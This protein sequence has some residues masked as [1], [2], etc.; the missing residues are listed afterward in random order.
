MTTNNSLEVVGVSKSFAGL[1]ALSEVSLCVE[2]GQIVGL[3]GPNGAGKTTLFNTLSGFIK[4]DQGSIQFGGRNLIGLKPDK[5]CK[6]GIARTFQIVKPFGEL[7]V[8]QNVAVGAFNRTS[9]AAEAEAEAWRVLEFVGLENKA[10]VPARSLT[11]SDRKR[12]EMARALATK[13]ELLLLD[14]VMAGLNPTEKTEVKHLVEKVRVAGTAI[15]IIEH[16]IR[17]IMDL[18][19]RILVIQYGCCIAEGDPDSISRDPHVIEAYMGKAYAA[20]EY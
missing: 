4:P 12:L 1:K 13:P 10:L 9:H 16:A 18:C 17:V 11:T 19:D 15:L 7:T 20:A 14:E 5:I 6:M 3:I 8:L 2:P